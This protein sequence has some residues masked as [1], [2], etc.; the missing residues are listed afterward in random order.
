[1]LRWLFGPPA[2]RAAVARAPG[3]ERIYLAPF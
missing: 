3:E 2:Q 1:M